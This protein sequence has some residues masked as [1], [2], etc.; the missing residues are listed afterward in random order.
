[1]TVDNE[2]IKNTNLLHGVSLDTTMERCKG[3]LVGIESIH[4][5]ADTAEVIGNVLEIVSHEYYLIPKVTIGEKG[6][7]IE[8]TVPDNVI[9]QSLSELWSAV[10][11]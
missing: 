9:A 3:L 7:F 8:N 5:Q 1:M 2:L 4:E 11:N 6:E 10:S